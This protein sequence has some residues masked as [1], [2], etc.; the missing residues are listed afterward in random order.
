[1]SKRHAFEPIAERLYIDEQYTFEAI[2][3]ELGISDRT[4]RT[5]ASNG[6]WAEKRAR[7]TAERTAL[8]EDL[9]RLARHLVKGLSIDLERLSADDATQDPDRDQR[10]ESRTNA[11]TR[12]LDKLPKARGYE[13]TVLADKATLDQQ[14]KKASNSEIASRLDELLGA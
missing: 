2:A 10:I 13:Q 1:M 5:W 4:I 3:A 12:L 11:L 6:Q 14:T 9:Y 8:H 7:L